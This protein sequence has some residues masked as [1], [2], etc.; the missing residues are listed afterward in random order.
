MSM[1]VHDNFYLRN[2]CPVCGSASPERIY[3]RPYSF[4]PIKDYLDSFYREHGAVNH[5]IL[6]TINYTLFECT[7]CSLI[8]QRAVP[9][10]EMMS[11]LYEGLIDPEVALTQHKNEEDLAGS[12]NCATEIMQ[13]I[14]FFSTSPSAL[15]LFDFGMGWGRWALMAKAFGCDAYGF[16]VSDK[17]IEHAR[18]NGIKVIAWDDI[19]GHRFDFINTEQVLE[20]VPDP[21]EVVLH[22]KSALKPGG[23]LKISVPTAHDIKRRLKIMDWSAKKFEKNSLNPVSPLEHVNYFSRNSI[24]WMGKKAGLSE[25]HVPLSIQ[26]KY[27]TNWS[28]IGRAIKN[29]CLPLY[30]NVLKKQN[31]VL[32]RNSA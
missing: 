3:E 8:Y 19:P 25:I 20:H 1:P 9:T 21:M 10:G 15:K 17:R 13:L 23:I 29:I 14:D 28:S 31:Y 27:V 11:W 24:A 26:Y 7:A 30:R 18:L 6:K 12:A 5:E 16:E 2:S 32:L 4:P 22:L